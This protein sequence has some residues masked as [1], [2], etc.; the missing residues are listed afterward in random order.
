MQEEGAS[1]NHYQRTLRQL[2]DRCEFETITV[3]QILRDKIVFGI[4]DS[5]V[6]ERLLRKKNLSLQ[7]NDEIFRRTR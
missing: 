6:R 7:K 3:D 2:A 5:K 1:Y 4:Q